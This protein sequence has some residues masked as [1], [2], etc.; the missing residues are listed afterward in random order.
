MTHLT[1]ELARRRAIAQGLAGMPG[2]TP[3]ALVKW[4]GAMQ[5]QDYPMARWSIAQRLSHNPADV[6]AAVGN[7]AILRAHVLRP[8][9]H[10]VPRDDLRWMQELTSAAVLQ[11]MR[12]YDRRNG[13]DAA[14]VARSTRRI[15]AAI[16]RHGHLTRH[17]IADV[18]KAD[19]VAL[20]PWVVGELLMHAELR[21]IVCSGAPRGRQQTYA[22]LEERAPHSVRLKRDE[23]LALLT[24]RYFQS[25]GP[26]TVKDF[27]WWSGLD[28]GD[29][30]RGID[31]AGRR[32]E[33]FEADGRTYLARAF[34]GA[35]LRSP[36]AHLIQP[37]DEIV[38]AYSES[39]H[40][41]DV[42]GLARARG[43][44]LLLR[45]LLVDGQVAGRWHATA[46]RACRIRLEPFRPF[47]AHEQK[48]VDRA[49]ARFAAA[50]PG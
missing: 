22:L 46:P 13:V 34:A 42:S 33:R 1:E 35:R 14:L 11:R 44:G 24:E 45:A 8:T 6:E 16:E 2:R 26:A 36:G 7:G 40:A 19:G 30:A 15:A 47:T 10:F 5:A 50:F 4:F 43:G 31:I 9:W 21:A 23:A 28:G 29:A 49:Q 41:V 48:A 20:S 18:L 25:H 38:V 12:P 39:R 37:Y 32:L 27:R 17:E 3:A